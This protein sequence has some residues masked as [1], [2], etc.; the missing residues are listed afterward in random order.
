MA[1][2]KK[3]SREEVLTWM[4]LYSKGYK[5]AA[6]HFGLKENTVK[7][8]V[9][10]A[11]R[12][13]WEAP[14]APPPPPDAVP[15]HTPRGGAEL[16]AFP[17]GKSKNRPPDAP[18][19]TPPKVS[20]NGRVMLTADAL[21]EEVAGL[22]RKSALM[23]LRY[24]AG[25]PLPGMENVELAPDQMAAL[26]AGGFSP[27]QVKNL[28]SLTVWDPRRVKESL[29]ALGILTDKCPDILSLGKKTAERT[30]DG[31]ADAGPTADAVAAAMGLDETG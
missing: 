17:G 19:R 7:G 15:N 13:D 2:P 6:K 29:I 5:F 8:W 22:M 16:L 4:S 1:P 31:K 3:P 14:S 20:A 11:K 27:G 21:D 26:V 9:R 24:A 12:T 30:T 23:L 18:P 25:E 28:L 10:W